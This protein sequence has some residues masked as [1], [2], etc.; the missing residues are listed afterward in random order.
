M[1]VCNYP[2][3]FQGAGKKGME[4]E[5][6][7]IRRKCKAPVSICLKH[8]DVPLILLFYPVLCVVFPLG[9]GASKVV[10]ADA[11]DLVLGQSNGSIGCAAASR[12]VGH[13]AV[14]ARKCSI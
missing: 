14:R 7:M 13:R 9:T 1:F 12:L 3:L 10:H 8:L 4:L 11:S 6:L 2:G 5:L